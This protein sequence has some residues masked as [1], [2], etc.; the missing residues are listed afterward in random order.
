MPVSSAVIDAK[1]LVRCAL[2]AALIA[3]LGL[4]PPIPVPVLPV[5]VTAQ[6]LGVMLAGAVLGPR[7]G[8]L[9]V[10]LFLGVVAVGFPLLAGGRGGLGAF[11]APSAGFLLG[12]V[13]GAFVVGA[14]AV[15]ATS[16][17][18]L[19]AACLTG[20]IGV[21]YLVGI[22]W[23]AAVADLSLAQASVASLAFVPGDI[24]KAVLAALAAR[25]VHRGYPAL[26]A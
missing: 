7:R 1:A 20:G 16:L 18:R 12:W 14:L 23:M 3:A 24:L 22:P 4:L 8:A 10:V 6:T 11:F 5:P 26:G 15:G 25:A 9:A 2:F 19:I 21:V 13:P 17:L